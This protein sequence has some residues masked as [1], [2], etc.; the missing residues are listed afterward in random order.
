MRTKETKSTRIKWKAKRRDKRGQ[1]RIYTRWLGKDGKESWGKTERLIC[2]SSDRD[3]SVRSF[4]SFS[5][6][7]LLLQSPSPFLSLSFSFRFFPFPNLNKASPHG[8][9]RKKE[10]EEEG[11]REKKKKR[12]KVGGGVT[13]TF[14]I[15]RLAH[16][17]GPRLSPRDNRE[18][19]SSLVIRGADRRSLRAGRL[20][21]EGMGE[22]FHPGPSLLPPRGIHPPLPFLL[23]LRHW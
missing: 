12:E 18:S 4:P 3:I 10:E 6:L 17:E 22:S 23:L 9:C 8:G 11:G 14:G 15:V 7:R 2:L 16:M 19:L 5:L 21:E 1:K 13:S 20:K